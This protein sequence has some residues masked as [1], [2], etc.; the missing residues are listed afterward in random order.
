MSGHESCWEKEADLKR[1]LIEKLKTNVEFVDV[2]T[3][4]L[5]S[6]GLS[7]YC[8]KY[9][10]NLGVL[11]NEVDVVLTT[12]KELIGIEIEYIKSSDKLFEKMQHS[13]G[14]TLL[15]LMLGFH[16]VGLL[17]FFGPDVSKETVENC[18]TLIRDLFKND[19]PDGTAHAVNYLCIRVI[20]IDE[21]TYRLDVV[22]SWPDY[23]EVFNPL[24]FGKWLLGVAFPNYR[25]DVEE[26][27][28]CLKV[29]LK[30]PI[31]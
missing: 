20:C 31:R 17:H 4:N 15:F 9:Y 24:F 12:K 26:R 10:R 8:R 5:S 1:W 13:I 25:R 28:R 3:A 22:K 18:G 7:D 29:A 6:A 14:Q 11:G 2:R 27:R 23:E 21:K 16:K 30:A 19:P